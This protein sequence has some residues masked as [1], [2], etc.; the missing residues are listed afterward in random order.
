MQLDD[1]FFLPLIFE[2]IHDLFAG[3]NMLDVSLGRDYELAVVAIGSS[4]N[5]NPLYIFYSKGLN[6]FLVFFYE[7]ESTNAASIGEG[8]MSPLLPQLPSPLFLFHRPIF[9]LLL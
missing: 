7:T 2:M 5:A 3:C 8:D 1:Q 6:L 4:S 9:S